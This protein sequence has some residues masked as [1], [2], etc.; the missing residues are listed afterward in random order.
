MDAND[1]DDHDRLRPSGLMQTKSS[2]AGVL[3]LALVRHCLW[4]G[5]QKSSIVFHGE[6][7]F[8]V[9]AAVTP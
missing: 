7:C 9:H 4:I 2:V 5:V 3:A 6:S 8:R 1:H